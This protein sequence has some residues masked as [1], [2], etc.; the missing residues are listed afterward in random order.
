MALEISNAEK[1]VETIAQ[2]GNDGRLV[3][4]DNGRYR[5]SLTTTQIRK[6]LSG[7]SSLT[8]RISPL[9]ENKL[10]QEIID[11]V[12][13]LKVRLAYQ[14]GRKGYEPVKPLYEHFKTT[15]TEVKE[16]DTWLKFANYVEAVVAYHRYYGGKD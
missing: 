14:A 16:K 13:M 8:N 12:Q 1:F 4:D 7:V 6:F 15:M 3:I 11:E 2:R 9:D 10:P 5:F